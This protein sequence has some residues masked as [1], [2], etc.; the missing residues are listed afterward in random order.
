MQLSTKSQL[1]SSKR[2]TMLDDAQKKTQQRIDNAERSKKRQCPPNLQDPDKHRAL[3]NKI[4]EQNYLN[5]LLNTKEYNAIF[6]D[7]IM[8]INEAIDKHK[9]KLED[10]E[11]LKYDYFIGGA[12]S[13]NNFFKDYYDENILSPF[14]KSAIH[15]TTADLYYFINNT[16]Y[17]KYIKNN[18]IKPIFDKYK[19]L[20]ETAIKSSKK[21]SMDDTIVINIQESDHLNGNRSL[22]NSQR[23]YFTL[24]IN[25]SDDNIA[26]IEHIFKNGPNKTPLSSRLQPVARPASAPKPPR[27]ASAP[28]PPRSTPAPK[29]PKSVPVPASRPVPT[30]VQPSRKKHGGTFPPRLSKV[31]LSLD[32]F[33]TSGTTECDELIDNLPELLEIVTVDAE[34]STLNYLNLYGLFICLKIITNKIYI[35]DKYNEQKI[36]EQIFNNIILIDEYK[37]KALKDI[38][39]KYKKVFESVSILFNNKLYTYI[40]LRLYATAHKEIEENINE[41]EKNIIEELR[42]FINETIL[43]IN[44]ALISFNKDPKIFGVFVAGGDALRRYKNDI[45]ETKD[46][47]TKIYVQDYQLN[48]KEFMYKIDD[49]ILRELCK[50]VCFLIRNIDL[51]FL[52]INKEFTTLNNDEIKYT[53]SNGSKN[54]QTNFRY[55]Q[56]YKNDNFPVDLYSL[57]YR[58]NIEIKLN[59][60]NETKF[61]YEYKIAFLDVVV[62]AL[63]NFEY[64]QDESSQIK[65]NVVSSNGI[66]I[67]SLEFLINDLKKTYYSDDSSVIRFVNN[68]IS[69]DKLRYDA[70]IALQKAN[71]FTYSINPSIIK[72]KLTSTEATG[73]Y[74]TEYVYSYK[75]KEDAEI[76]TDIIKLPIL[77]E[78]R[79]DEDTIIARHNLDRL[80][81]YDSAYDSVK[82]D[83]DEEIFP[84]LYKLYLSN[85]KKLYIWNNQRIYNFSINGLTNTTKQ[86]GTYDDNYTDEINYLNEIIDKKYYKF[87]EIITDDC[88]DDKISSSIANKQQ[89]RFNSLQKKIKE[90][91]QKSIIKPLKK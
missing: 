46:I 52:N 56:V 1:K 17:V 78:N 20:I 36:R 70:L 76:D 13:W 81:S 71:K 69:K 48:D 42:P 82:Y 79:E 31:I 60:E 47:D 3:N 50:L 23:I 18:I 9:K 25:Q 38:A 26:E 34:G 24:H 11:E 77:F 90:K 39:E 15:N 58:C 55:R 41:T 53:L 33:N 61:K 68:K 49:I 84:N 29:P 87:N 10:E 44:R 16:A 86:G 54:V 72:K 22:I 6:K 91:L 7:F 12:R 5:D 8:E 59:D 35:T 80:N 85:F 64:I 40:F 32:I 28:K 89:I 67:S 27:P 4:D 19:V 14:E 2:A 43:K 62:E 51:L 30:R 63:N 73:I 57:D 74:K 21:V 65:P 75:S 88:I 83:K 37:I 66:P 45:S